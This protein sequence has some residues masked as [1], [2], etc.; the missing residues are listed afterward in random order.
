MRVY[1]DRID[2]M[3]LGSLEDRLAISDLFVRHATALDASDVEAVVDCFT[4]D[5]VQQQADAARPLRV[6]SC[7]A[8]WIWRFTRRVVFHDHDYTLEGI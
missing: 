3:A 8:W 2:P 4:A 6:R 1:T 5:A 7:P